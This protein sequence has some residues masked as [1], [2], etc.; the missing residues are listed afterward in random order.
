MN[1]EQIFK[2]AVALTM[3]CL[4]RMKKDVEEFVLER[5]VKGEDRPVEKSAA[6]IFEALMDSLQEI[7][8]RK[9]F[10]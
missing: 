10:Q 2:N 7:A 3:K 8:D 9:K 6:V 5:F 1:E 4:D